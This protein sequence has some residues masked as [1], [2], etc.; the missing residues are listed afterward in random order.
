MGVND[1]IARNRKHPHK[2]IVRIGSIAVQ[3]VKCNKGKA[4][5]HT[6]AFPNMHAVPRIV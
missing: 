5:P 3:A 4:A 2:R 6:K 1:S